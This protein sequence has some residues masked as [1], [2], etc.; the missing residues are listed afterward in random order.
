MTGDGGDFLAHLAV[1]LG[2]YARRLRSEGLAVP[3][4]VLEVAEWAGDCAR[5]RQT[6]TVLDAFAARLDGPHMSPRLLTKADTAQVLGVSVRTLERLAA[7]GALVPVRVEGSVRYRVT[8]VDA[9]VS[10]LGSSF[11]DDLD[12]KGAA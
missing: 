2:L 11:R 1:A 10:G 4:L 3:P 12:R 5:N 7:T 9:Y 8:D 6:A